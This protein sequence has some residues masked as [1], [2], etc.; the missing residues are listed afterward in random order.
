MFQESPAALLVTDAAM[1]I[2]VTNPAACALLRVQ[3]EMADGIEILTFFDTAERAAIAGKFAS[4]FRR[5]R[6]SI[7]FEGRLIRPSGEAFPARLSATLITNFDA[8]ATG[9]FITMEELTE[10]PL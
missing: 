8:D 9:C 5:E 10:D 1:H 3:A 7:Q 4:L 6:L 2:V